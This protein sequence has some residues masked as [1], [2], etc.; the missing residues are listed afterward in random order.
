ML[1]HIG[2]RQKAFILI[3][4]DILVTC[5]LD[6][7]MENVS[8][9]TKNTNQSHSIK[10]IQ[11]HVLGSNEIQND[12]LCLVPLVKQRFDIHCC[13]VIWLDEQRWH[14]ML[15]CWLGV[16]SLDWF[17]SSRPWL[18]YINF[19]LP[20]T[21]CL[22]YN[23]THSSQIP[24]GKKSKEDECSLHLSMVAQAKMLW[25]FVFSYGGHKSLFMCGCLPPEEASLMQVTQLWREYVSDFVPGP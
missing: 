25:M 12:P 9:D 3:A 23:I 6:V 22:F 19:K 18:E 16:W 13:T 1:K 11:L 20:L 8:S 4:D 10:Q 7:T 21:L 15:N 24:P 14:Q 17:T 2:P 5:H